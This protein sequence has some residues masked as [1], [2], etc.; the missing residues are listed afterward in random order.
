MNQDWKFHLGPCP[1]GETVELDD[2]A[3]SGVSLP[4]TW[5]NVDGQDGCKNGKNINETDYFRGD[6]WYRRWI[7]IASEERQKQFFLRFEG[8]NTQAEVFVDGVR[9]GAHK[10]GY[11][12]FCFDVTEQLSAGGRHLIAVRVNNERAED[13]APLTA[14]FTFYGGI[15]RPMELIVTEKLHFGRMDHGARGLRIETPFVSREKA[16][17]SLCAVLKNETDEEKTVAVTATLGAAPSWER[18]P[19]ITRTPWNAPEL[20]EAV[21]PLTQEKEITL[22]AHSEAE[23]QFSF[24]VRQPH[25]WDGRHDPFRYGAA[26]RVEEGGVCLD[27]LT[28]FVGFRYFNVD[29]KQ[30]FFLNGNPYPLRGVSRHQDRLGIGNALTKKEH[31]EDFSM[32]YDMGV[33][34]IRLA[35]YPQ[36]EYFYR[37]CDAYGIVVWAEIPFVDLVGGEGSYDQPDAERSAFFDVTRQQLRELIRQHGNHPAIVCWGLQ[38]EVKAKFDDVMRPLMEELHAL[39]KTEDP[40]R[41][42][43]QATNQKTA[44]H[45][46]SDLIAWNVYPGWYGMRKTQLGWFM[47]KSRPKDRPLGISEYGAGGNP[48]QHER[49]PKRPKHDGDWHPEEYQTASHEAFLKDINKRPYLWCT[50]VWNMFDFG[51]DGRNEGAQPGRNDKG[52]VTFDRAIKKDSYYVY[53]SNWYEFPMLQIAE[54]RFKE[55]KRKKQ[56]FKVYSNCDS[57]E[58]FLNGQSLGVRRQEKNGQ[59]GVFLWKNQRLQKGM[60]RVRAVAKGQGEELEQ[61]SVFVLS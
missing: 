26:L 35:H 12:A 16:E 24:T 52:L 42:T 31:D 7:C 55:R 40:S 33:N 1:Q 50:F 2:S 32:I 59:K 58:L 38:N 61:E 49:N 47:D 36:A 11:T 39:A 10:G 17:C 34:A 37:L 44:Y 23:V 57:V 25:L 51:S 30:G 22:A 19:Y 21:P 8:A 20:E 53:Q 46:K 13:I 18:N 14:D 27:E 6:G 28:D 5:N 60:N 29:A 3:W 48:A 54:R 4:H 15:Y 41:F 56:T 9:V 45:W 43:T